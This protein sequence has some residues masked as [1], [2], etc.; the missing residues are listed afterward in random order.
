MMMAAMAVTRYAQWGA[1]ESKVVASVTLIFVKAGWKK[2]GRGWW[3]VDV[4]LVLQF[5]HTLWMEFMGV[6]W[7]LQSTYIPEGTGGG[8]WMV[9]GCCSSLIVFL[10]SPWEL[11][12]L[13]MCVPS[14]HYHHITSLLHCMALNVESVIQ[15]FTIRK[16]LGFI[17]TCNTQELHQFFPEPRL[18]S[19][20]VTVK[21][22]PL[23]SSL[24]SP[25]L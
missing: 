7:I 24:H 13:L 4:V 25:M 16:W 18:L 19:F 1:C 20:E 10:V 3:C 5:T 17:G 23:V 15:L 9:C 14:P 11:L 21:S 6:V 8:V 2:S 22:M 12:P